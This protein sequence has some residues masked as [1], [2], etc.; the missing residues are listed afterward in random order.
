MTV[1]LAGSLD[2]RCRIAIGGLGTS[3]VT[4]TVSVVAL[5]S[6][7]VGRGFATLA[8]CTATESSFTSC[9]DARSTRLAG[10]SD[11]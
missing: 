2:F 4:K 11:S 3:R 8:I 9:F 1:C 10:L 7:A 5:I 6:L